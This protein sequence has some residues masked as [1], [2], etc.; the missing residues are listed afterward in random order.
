MATDAEFYGTDVSIYTGELITGPR[1]LAEDIV[2]RITCDE[3]KMWWCP[4]TYDC[5]QLLYKSLTQADVSGLQTTTEQLFSDD[6]R[7]ASITANITLQNNNLIYEITVIPVESRPALK[8]TYSTT[9][10]G[11]SDISVGVK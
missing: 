3:G 5:R 2:K 8:I 7:I 9:T 6:P 10:D 1:V 11:K 4:N